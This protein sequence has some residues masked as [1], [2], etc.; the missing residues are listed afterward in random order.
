[1][2]SISLLIKMLLIKRSIKSSRKHSKSKRNKEYPLKNS[3]KMKFSHC[4]TF[5]KIFTPLFVC[6]FKW[7]AEILRSSER[8]KHL[9]NK[10]FLEEIL[11]SL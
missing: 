2:K 8:L 4:K 1:M 11:N 7:S 6:T 9:T 10:K 5:I 3:F